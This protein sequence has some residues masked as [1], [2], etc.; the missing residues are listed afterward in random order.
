MVVGFIGYTYTFFLYSFV[1]DVF[2]F[3]L[4]AMAE[5]RVRQQ[6]FLQAKHT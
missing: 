1:T 3:V 2:Q 6:Q 5:L 4:V